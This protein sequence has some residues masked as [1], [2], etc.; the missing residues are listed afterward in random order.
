[1]EQEKTYKWTQD[2]LRELRAGTLTTDHRRQLETLAKEDPFVAD[3]LEG[4]Q[5][6]PDHPH[7]EYLESITRKI[8]PYRLKRR[9][10]L[11]PN[12]TVTAI[13]AS[14][15]LIVG[16]W[17]VMN[18]L[19]KDEQKVL[20]SD[21]TSHTLV[22][23]GQ[24]DSM[25]MLPEGTTSASADKAGTPDEDPGAH[26]S[27]ET[28]RALPADKT[29]D[30]K[31]QPAIDKPHD[32]AT[33]MESGDRN[34]AISEPAPPPTV[35]LENEVGKADEKEAV[36]VA[37]DKPAF[38]DAFLANQIDPGLMSRRVT[39][40]VTNTSGEPLIG[41]N[42]M[43]RNTNL[44]TTSDLSG[45]F[46]LFLPSPE[47]MIDV[48]YS[49]YNDTAVTL[50]QGEEDVAITLPAM[51]LV[52]DGVPAGKISGVARAEK[53]AD[54]ARSEASPAQAT[55]SFIDYLKL[56]SKYPLLD[57]YL[58]SGRMVTLAFSI[59]AEGQPAQ[60]RIVNSSGDKNYDDEAVRL[61]RKGPKWLCAS[62][63]YPCVG[64]YT[65]YFRE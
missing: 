44:G 42:L 16:F 13:A 8:K 2:R 7:E 14:L 47:T 9:R 53:S 64:E 3:A 22:I 58:V 32:V 18:R 17:A 43:V 12:L 33:R 26:L 4:Y 57:E 59:P 31:T 63:V 25:A 29:I 19:Y 40:R 34:V 48:T 45:R 28:R 56:N 54:G 24:G 50:R 10:W 61:L 1:M 23:E 65:I 60:I 55:Q 6:H 51:K 30:K 5:L 41:A 39:G 36:N 11:I 35:V 15:I 20:A 27:R 21:E 38:N 62:G 46:E 52:T 37:S 49:G